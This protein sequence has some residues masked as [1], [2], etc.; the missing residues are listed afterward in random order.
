M[1]PQVEGVGKKRRGVFVAVADRVIRPIVEGQIRSFLNDHPEIASGCTRHVYQSK[2]AE[3]WITDSLSKRITR[4]L[5]CGSTTAR[6]A[7]ALLE[8]ITGARSEA[9]DG[10]S[11]VARGGSGGTQAA[12]AVSAVLGDPR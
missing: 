5:T 1:T 3:A 6:L 4:D 2:T 9:S 11:I 10:T 8:G 7:K 12:R